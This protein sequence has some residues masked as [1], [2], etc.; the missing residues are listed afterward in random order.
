MNIVKKIV[1]ES[2]YN[3]KCPYTMTPEY[4]SVHNTANDVSARNEI[5][6]MIKNNNI[7]SVSK[8]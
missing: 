4:I 3:I 2:K 1:P 8:I 7:V 6:Y 5:S